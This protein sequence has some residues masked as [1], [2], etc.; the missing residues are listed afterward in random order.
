MGSRPTHTKDFTGNSRSSMLSKTLPLLVLVCAASAF[1]ID[2]N[3]KDEECFNTSFPKYNRTIIESNTFD[4]R[5]E[6]SGSI[7]NVGDWF[8]SGDVYTIKEGEIYM[9]NTTAKAMGEICELVDA[10]DGDWCEGAMNEIGNVT[11]S[12][13]VGFDGESLMAAMNKM[14]V[15]VTK[16]GAPWVWGNCTHMSMTAVQDMNVVEF[17]YVSWDTSSV[18]GGSDF[19]DWSPGDKLLLSGAS[20]TITSIVTLFVSLLV[21]TRLF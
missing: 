17:T 10:F 16:E 6:H 8:D 7:F 1:N 2:D 20:S 5:I 13:V 21:S 4:V 3:K 12:L 19:P 18:T 14:V 11:R 15:T 9:Y